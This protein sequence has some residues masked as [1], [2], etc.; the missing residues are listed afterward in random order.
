MC[1]PRIS[2]Y[3][4]MNIPLR[5]EHT[6]RGRQRFHNHLWRKSCSE[7]IEFKFVREEI[8]PQEC[9]PDGG[10]PLRERQRRKRPINLPIE[11]P[12]WLVCSARITAGQVSLT[13]T[14]F[15]L[16]AGDSLFNVLMCLCL[17]EE[18][19]F[20]GLAE[21]TNGQ[22]KEFSCIAFHCSLT[23]RANKRK[24]ANRWT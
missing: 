17:D 9:L 22:T 5:L 3:L 8:K 16:F 15:T 19:G 12:T 20:D 11:R 2:S 13:Q 1:L 6:Q 4:A 10:G 23:W 7:G 18:N 14:K 24:Q 21:Q